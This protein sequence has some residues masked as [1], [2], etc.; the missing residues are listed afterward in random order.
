MSEKGK[1]RGKKRHA[2]VKP[3]RAAAKVTQASVRSVADADIDDIFGNIAEKKAKKQQRLEDAAARKEREDA[4]MQKSAEA[5]SGGGRFCEQ[6]SRYGDLSKEKG[7][8][9]DFV[10]GHAPKPV[11]FD[12]ASSL[13]VY[14]EAALGVSLPNSGK[15]KDCPFD[16]DCCF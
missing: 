12:S 10:K 14:K 1:K 5:F 15:T 2:D 7:K 13:P 16:C 9:Y 11:R 4:E 8:D 3:S 6:D